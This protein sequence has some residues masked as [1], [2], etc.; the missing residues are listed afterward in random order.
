MVWKAALVQ[1]RGP[2]SGARLIAYFYGK[3][4]RVDKFRATTLPS[5]KTFSCT[6]S[7]T[8]PPPVASPMHLT[9]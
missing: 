6:L 7:C 8:L 3:A 9:L 4:P 2:I 1:F 5:T